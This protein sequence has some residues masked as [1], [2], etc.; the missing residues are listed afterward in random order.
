MSGKST[1]GLN[2]LKGSSSASRGSPSKS[3]ASYKK[4]ESKS[5]SK[6]G[7]GM[8][9]L[10]ASY[11]SGSSGSSKSSSSSRK[12]DDKR[13][14]IILL[15]LNNVIFRF[16]SKWFRKQIFLFEIWLWFRKRREFRFFLVLQQFFFF[17]L[18]VLQ[19]HDRRQADPDDEEESGGKETEVEEV[20]LWFYIE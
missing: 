2:V 7:P 5:S 11:K 3:D 1:G 16:L 20:K 18:V 12:L 10:A 17:L 19:S 6:L 13:K 14:N 4:P 8:A 15:I 9:G